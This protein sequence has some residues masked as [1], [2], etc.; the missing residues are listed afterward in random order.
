MKKLKT[1]YCD[2]KENVSSYSEKALLLHGDQIENSDVLIYILVN[3][4]AIGNE[5]FYE[6][7]LEVISKGKQN[8]YKI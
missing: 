4:E 8:N 1:T 3:M 5:E 7:H 2:P 6:L